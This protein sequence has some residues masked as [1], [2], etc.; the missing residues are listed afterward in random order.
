M[1]F[2]SV[3]VEFDGF[4]EFANRLFL[5]A[6]LGVCGPQGVVENRPVGLEPDGILIL[7]NSF[8]VFFVSRVDHAEPITGVSHIGIDCECL[9]ELLRCFVVLSLSFIGHTQ[10]VLEPTVFRGQFHGPAMLLNGG[11]Q[12]VLV[13]HDSPQQ[14]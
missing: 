14:G 8:L 2:G 3:V 1:C 12:L 9:D 4:L 10:I 7:L 11:G 5:A 13:R 6:D